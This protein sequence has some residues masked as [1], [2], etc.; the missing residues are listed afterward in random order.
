MD[1][2][3]KTYGEITT[4]KT[5]RGIE[6]HCY[7]FERNRTL[8]IGTLKGATYEA[9]KAILRNP[10]PSFTLTQAELAAAFEHGAQFIRIIPPD[11]AAT[12]AI[13]LADFKRLAVPYHN[14]WYGPQWRT[15]LGAFDRSAATAPRNAA[16]DNPVAASSAPL[17]EQP[18]MTGFETYAAKFPLPQRRGE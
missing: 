12:Y 9:V 2:Y 5:K 1:E 10:E 18:I 6:F 3:T 8:H 17:W 14:P 11:K 15:P 16:R 4:R 13:S 7:N